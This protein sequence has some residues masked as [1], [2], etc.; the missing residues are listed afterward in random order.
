M[1]SNGNN[2]KIFYGVN[3]SFY[4]FIDVAWQVG[5]RRRQPKLISQVSA[6]FSFAF[7]RTAGDSVAARD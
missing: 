5:E 1:I 3:D 2:R 7:R 6:P 4:V